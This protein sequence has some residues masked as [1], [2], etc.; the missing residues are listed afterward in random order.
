MIDLAWF[1][2]LSPAISPAGRPGRGRPPVPGPDTTTGAN[3]PAC[4]RF[5]WAAA[6]RSVCRV[7][8]AV[9]CFLH[10]IDFLVL[11]P[12]TSNVVYLDGYGKRRVIGGG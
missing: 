6:A 4:Y 12:N 7:H 5:G 3:A 9:D 1:V 11:I 8:R 2:R 10:F